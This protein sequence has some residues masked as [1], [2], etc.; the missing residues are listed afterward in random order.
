[1]NWIPILVSVGLFGL[2]YGFYE[3]GKYMKTQNKCLANG[4]RTAYH[5]IPFCFAV[6]MFAVSC[7]YVILGVIK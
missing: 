2:S 4:E 5:I 1:M 7:W 6:I 3:M